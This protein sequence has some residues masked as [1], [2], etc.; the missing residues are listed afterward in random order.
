MYLFLYHSATLVEFVSFIHASN[1]NTLYQPQVFITDSWDGI[2]MVLVVE[3][4]PHGRQWIYLFYIVYIK[5]DGET[6][7]KF[8][9][10]AGVRDP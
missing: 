10:Y 1:S 2:E 4:L 6:I 7:D 9:N 8:P 3:I 5:G